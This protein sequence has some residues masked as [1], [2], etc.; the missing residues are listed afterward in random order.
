VQPDAED[1]HRHMETVDLPL[2]R[3]GDADLVPGAKALEAVNA[4]LR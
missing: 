3:L 1:L 2:N 4:A